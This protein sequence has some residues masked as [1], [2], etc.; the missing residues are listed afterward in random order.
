VDSLVEWINRD[1]KLYGGNLIEGHSQGWKSRK[2]ELLEVLKRRHE[3]S[4][5][6]IVNNVIN[7]GVAS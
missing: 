3:L 1:G 2:K 7:Q 6:D 5:L 4:R